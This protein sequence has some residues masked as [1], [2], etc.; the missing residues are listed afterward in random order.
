[1]AEK[2]LYYVGCVNSPYGVLKQPKKCFTVPVSHGIK[3]IGA[4]FKL[5]L[6]QKLNSEMVQIWPKR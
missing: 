2:A 3:E 6:W 5:L 4:K 1:M